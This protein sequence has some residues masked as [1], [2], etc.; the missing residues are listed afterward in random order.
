MSYAIYNV[1]NIVAYI[2]LHVITWLSPCEEQTK[3]IYICPPI[4]PRIPPPPPYTPENVDL[5][6]TPPLY[7]G[8]GPRGRGWG[9]GP[10][11]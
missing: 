2:S 4:Y 3:D 8:P 6:P 5:H 9:A 1:C 10:G 11:V 7:P